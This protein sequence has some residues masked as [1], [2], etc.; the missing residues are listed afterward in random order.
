LI[1]NRIDGSSKVLRVYQP[2]EINEE[3]LKLYSSILGLEV[4][5]DEEDSYLVID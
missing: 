3:R 5:K 1:R 2:D 4:F